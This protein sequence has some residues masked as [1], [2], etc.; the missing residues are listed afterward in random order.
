MIDGAQ[1]ARYVAKKY[2]T[3]YPCAH[4]DD[5]YSEALYWL[6]RYKGDDPRLLTIKLSRRIIEYLRKV[7]GEK[8]DHSFQERFFMYVDSETAPEQ[9]K[10]TDHALRL[11]R[12]SVKQ[13]E[14]FIRR[15]NGEYLREIGSDL[16]ICEMA[17]CDRMR[18]A[19]KRYAA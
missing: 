9:E 10:K 18:R 12:L 1:I 7:F 19:K 14:V 2:S 11:R 16:G 6:C 8:Q 15:M 13:K 3:P 5:L 4:E 17:V